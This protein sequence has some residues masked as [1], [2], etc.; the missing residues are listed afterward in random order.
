MSEGQI[1]P[2]I[3]KMAL[4]QFTRVTKQSG[5]LTSGLGFFIYP[6]AHHF[7]PLVAFTSDKQGG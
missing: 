4:T 5:V 1:H 2:F 7:T 3:L 6:R